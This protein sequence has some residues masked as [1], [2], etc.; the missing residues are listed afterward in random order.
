MQ[1][2]YMNLARNDGTNYGA[3]PVLL[4]PTC[5]QGSYKDSALLIE[6]IRQAWKI[7][8]YGE[9][10]HGSI[11]S[12]ASDGDPKHRP[13]LYL[14][15]VVRELTPADALYAHLGNLPGLNL[16]TGPN[17][18]T[19]DLDYKHDFKREQSILF[20][21]G[22]SQQVVFQVSANYFARVRASL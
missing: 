21:F 22:T 3:K 15:C 2:Q 8:E 1:Q 10:L 19:Q 13:A 9:A 7:S 14:H 16:Y 6:M 4:L 18:E 12:I 17:F 5:K 20:C 11:W